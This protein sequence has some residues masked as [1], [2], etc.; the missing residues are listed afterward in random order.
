MN[1]KYSQQEINRVA[2]NLIGKGFI[3]GSVADRNND[4]VWSRITTH[5]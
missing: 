5:F 1:R 3:K 4:V 2:A